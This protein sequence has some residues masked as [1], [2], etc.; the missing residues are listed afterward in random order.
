MLPV[1]LAALTITLQHPPGLVARI[2]TPA[3]RL[4]VAG[5][6]LTTSADGRR[7]YTGDLPPACEGGDS[8]SIHV[9]VIDAATGL[10]LTTHTESP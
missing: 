1:V 9:S 5:R 4:Q 7:L 2:G 3:F 6:L 8:K 10:H